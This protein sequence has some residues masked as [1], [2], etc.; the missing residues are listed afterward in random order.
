[1]SDSGQ[2]IGGTSSNN[3]MNGL[4]SSHPYPLP[5]PVVWRPSIPASDGAPVNPGA[6]MESC[7]SKVIM[8][9]VTGAGCGLL[10]GMFLGAMGDM[11]PVQLLHGR[12]VPQL[13]LKEQM[14]AAYVST[15][16]RSTSM[17]KSFAGFS[18]LL[19]GSECVIEKMRA[20]DGASGGGGGVE[21]IFRFV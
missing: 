11:Q 21:T 20:R 7:G 6:L 14:R 13:P 19:L 9:I 10:F 2:E 5:F 15:S 1:M 17:A 12:E 8:G 16:Q 18:A 3:L 4:N